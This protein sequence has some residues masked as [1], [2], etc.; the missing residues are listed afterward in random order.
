MCIYIIP[1]Y[2]VCVLNA[3][4]PE[5]LTAQWQTREDTRPAGSPTYRPVIYEVPYQRLVRTM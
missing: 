2:A 5:D 4:K 1:D 3:N